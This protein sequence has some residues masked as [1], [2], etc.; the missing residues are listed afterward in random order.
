MD[1]QTEDEKI[2]KSAKTRKTVLNAVEYSHW[3]YLVLMVLF[4]V[5]WMVLTSV[6]G[7]DYCNSE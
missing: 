7:Y 4:P 2:E 3:E 6:K 5:C 1:S